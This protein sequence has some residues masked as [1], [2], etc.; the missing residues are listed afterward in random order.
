MKYAKLTD[1]QFF[2]P[3]TDIEVWYMRTEAFRDLCCGSIGDGFKT[4]DPDNLGK[5]HILLGAVAE[6]DS[7]L[8]IRDQILENL[9]RNLQGEIWSPEGEANE[10]IE[11]KGLAHTS[12]CVGDMVRFKDGKMYLV[13]NSGWM[14]FSTVADDSREGIYSKK[15]GE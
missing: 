5:T 8:G 4:F 6:E 12:M 13:D 2:K 7:V 10:L 11:S 14:Q 15:P 1:C 9:F 3:G